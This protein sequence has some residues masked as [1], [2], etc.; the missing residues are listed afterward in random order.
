MGDIKGI[1][2]NAD[3]DRKTSHDMSFYK[4]VINSIPTAVLSVNA[5]LKITGFNP[6]ATVETGYTEKEVLGRY[7]GEILRGSMCTDQCPLKSAIKE[8]RPVSFVATTIRKKNGE[9]IPVRMNSAGLFDDGGRL[10]GAVESFWDI[11]PLKA[12]QRERDN[13]ISMFAHD[14]KSSITIIGG[15]VSRLLKR[16]NS[17]SNEKQKRHL[18]IIRKESANLEFIVNDFLD[19]ARLRTEK[20]QLDLSSTPLDKELM[21]LFDAYQNEAVR[22]QINFEFRKNE[23]S[24]VIEGDAKHLRRVFTNILDN[25]FKFS[26]AD[27]KITLISDAR[28]NEA[29]VKIIDQGCGID[30]DDLPYVFDAFHRGKDTK[31]YKGSGIGL[32]AAK[33]IVEAHGGR[34]KVESRLGTGSE[35]TVILPKIKNSS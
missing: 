26:K 10:L 14:M 16:M 30:P 5:D 35:F 27:T 7:C 9:T 11:S 29:I 28:E 20:L 4:F 12:M 19:F 31:R 23:T 2:D 32:A 15:I 17:L 34:I 24:S 25:A 33:T 21:E 8:Y 22:N 13:L 6:K 18:E 3:K 1:S